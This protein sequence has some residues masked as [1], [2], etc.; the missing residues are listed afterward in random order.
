MFIDLKHTEASFSPNLMDLFCLHVRVTQVPRARDVVIFV[1]M[2]MTQPIAVLL[3]HAH[4]H[5]HA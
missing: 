3:V 5:A 1:L 2:T 4:G